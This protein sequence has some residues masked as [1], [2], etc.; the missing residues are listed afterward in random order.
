MQVIREMKERLS[1]E[2]KMTEC[3]FTRPIL[4]CGECECFDVYA[5]FKGKSETVGNCLHFGDFRQPF[6]I[7]SHWTPC[8][9][10][11]WRQMIRITVEDVIGKLEG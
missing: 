5:R 10:R 11:A 6:R 8:W 2:Y 7:R 4:C 1:L 9:W 3:P